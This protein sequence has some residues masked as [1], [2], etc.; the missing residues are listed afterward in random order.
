MPR[1]KLLDDKKIQYTAEEEALADAEAK[2]W[3]DGQADRD[4]ADRVVERKLE[5]KV[6]EHLQ[7]FLDARVVARE[8]PC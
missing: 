1:Y 7:D 4:L 6:M 5:A 3:L 2:T 8:A